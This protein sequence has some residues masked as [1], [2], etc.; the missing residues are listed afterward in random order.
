MAED[1]AARLKQANLVIKAYIAGFEQVTDFDDKFK[2]LYK[3]FL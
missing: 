1:I 3:K 2:N